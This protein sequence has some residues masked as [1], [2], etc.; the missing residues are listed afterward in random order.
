MTWS[1]V[2]HL[3]PINDP[4]LIPL[5]SAP[6]SKSIIGTCNTKSQY[7]FILPSALLHW[8]YDTGM[9]L[10]ET[11]HDKP[12]HSSMDGIVSKQRSSK[13]QRKTA[14]N[15]TRMSTTT[16]T[17]C[18]S[19]TRMKQY[20]TFP[21]C[22]HLV[23]EETFDTKKNVTLRN[24]PSQDTSR[25]RQRARLGASLAHK[26][27]LNYSTPSQ[28]CYK[29]GS[30][31]IYRKKE[32][33]SGPQTYT[34]CIFLNDYDRVLA[35]D[36]AGKMD[37]IRLPQF[38]RNSTN[39]RKNRTTL[40]TTILQELEIVQPPFDYNASS[41]LKLKPLNGGASFVVG[42]ATGNYHTV[43]T[44]RSQ[45]TSSNRFQSARTT[46][47]DSKCSIDAYTAYG[48][49]RRY[50]R[51]RTNPHLS[52]QRLL[53]NNGRNYYDSHNFRQV[54]G[55]D[56]CKHRVATSISFAP[57]TPNQQ[58]THC[59]QAMWDFWET[60]A[61]SVLA[62]HVDAEHDCFS[63][64]DNRHKST[65]VIDT[66][67]DDLAPKRQANITSCA[68]VS[69]HCVATS[70]VEWIS[71]S[72][73]CSEHQSNG[74]LQKSPVATVSSCIKLWDL[75]MLHAQRQPLTAMSVVPSFPK[76]TTVGAKPTTMNMELPDDIHTTTSDLA[77]T[78]LQ[79]PCSTDSGTMLVTTQSPTS[80][81]HHVLDLGRGHV[82]RTIPPS[83]SSTMAVSDSHHAMAC[84]GEHGDVLQIYNLLDNAHD[85]SRRSG[86]KRP[87]DAGN[88][89]GT[90]LT[91]VL[92]DRHGLATQLSC[93]AMNYSGTSLL[94]GS[95]DGDLF[96]WRGS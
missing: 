2:P 26:Q 87:Y 28:D 74:I 37:V 22:H 20:R 58:K 17:H 54:Y 5:V 76:D 86:S 95:I 11:F 94:G 81:H 27:L 35:A 23:D 65:V 45:V 71:T 4:T 91:P 57:A 62:A 48:P 90:Q 38:P 15:A 32:D 67:S 89:A 42:M 44:E 59:N 8:N 10:W 12:H 56:E 78:Q 41:A 84:V 50:H 6:N 93:V 61:S 96:L 39:L 16:T 46:Q 33:Y 14:G 51:D 25:R 77:I 36:A 7:R 34:S 9:S 68:F 43:D 31:V 24:Y 60:H 55:W 73:S 19:S 83:S 21:C 92:K 80:V 82:T 66:S 1:V 53:Q 3:H 70:H 40:G 49:K 18:S 88:P 29:D 79:T 85:S 47:H 69:Q 75:R 63:L 13:N 30:H 64:W 52:L 72:S